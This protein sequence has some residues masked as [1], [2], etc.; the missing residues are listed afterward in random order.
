MDSPND[1]LPARG[2]A[3]ALGRAALAVVL[4]APIV[5]LS[6]CMTPEDRAFY[7]RGWLNPSE[8][9]EEQPPPREFTDPTS[10]QPHMMGPGNY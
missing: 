5:F 8:L 9:D 2:A 6:G 4:L 10:V 1:P 3:S 7:G